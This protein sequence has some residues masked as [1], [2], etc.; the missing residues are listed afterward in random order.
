MS[1]TAKTP[2]VGVSQLFSLAGQTAVVTGGTRGIGA[3]CAIALA[4]AGA[5]ICLVQR[6]ESNT[7]TRDAVRAIGRRAEIVVCDL[8]DLP[9]VKTVFD[10]AVELMGGQIQIMVNCGG[11]QRRAPA[12]EFPEDYWDEASPIS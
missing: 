2:A 4:E 12:V 5:D 7:A 11:I 10:R 1:T 3:A 8:A 9:A 6:D